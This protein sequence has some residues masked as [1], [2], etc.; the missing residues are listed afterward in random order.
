MTSEQIAQQ[1]IPDALLNEMISLCKGDHDLFLDRAKKY[2]QENAHEIL[3]SRFFAENGLLKKHGVLQN[4]KESNKETLADIKRIINTAK[5]LKEMLS[6][7]PDLSNPSETPLSGLA[8]RM[9][10]HM[11]ALDSGQLYEGSGYRDVDRRLHDW[12]NFIEL[13][14]KHIIAFENIQSDIESLYKKGRLNT[15]ER[16]EGFVKHIANMYATATDRKFTVGE[17][18]DVDYLSEGMRFAQKAME[19]L[20]TPCSD[21]HKSYQD[22]LAS[23]QY[24]QENFHSA[25]DYV[26]RNSLGK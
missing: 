19:V 3:F 15:V 25:C 6:V 26:R 13:L 16:L 18:G 4:V 7:I 5:K 24:T 17:Y 11:Y 22:F 23:H 21:S 1:A 2:R 20:K 10:I 12:S 14:D 9:E 8:M